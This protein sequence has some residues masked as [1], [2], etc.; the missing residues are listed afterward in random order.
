MRAARLAALLMLAAAP[1]AAQTLT[2]GLATPP[3]ALEQH[4][5]AHAQSSA[6]LQP[7]AA[8]KIFHD[9]AAAP[10]PWTSGCE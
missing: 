4:Y 2:V 3:T 9:T 6:T 10:A 1:A 7:P 5:H 8:R